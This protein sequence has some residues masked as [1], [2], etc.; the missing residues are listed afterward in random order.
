[1]K[2]MG[3]W[4]AWVAW[5]HGAHGRMSARVKLLYAIPITKSPAHAKH[6]LAPPKKIAPAKLSLPVKWR[7][8]MRFGPRKC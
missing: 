7:K 2:R 8:N 5:V 4:D 3:I 1:M 6:R